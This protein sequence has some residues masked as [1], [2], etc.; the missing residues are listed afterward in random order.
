M[1]PG[2][3]GY[4]LG[5]FLIGHWV[6][7]RDY[8]THPQRHL[9]AYRRVLWIALPIGLIVFGTVTQSSSVSILGIAA[10]EQVLQIRERAVGGA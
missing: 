3:F 6:G 7:R 4:A 5:R 10:A 1:I 2:W 9:D 8:L